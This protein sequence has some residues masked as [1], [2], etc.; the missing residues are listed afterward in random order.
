[1]VD[2]MNDYLRLFPTNQVIISDKPGWLIMVNDTLWLFP[3]KTGDER[4]GGG[5]LGGGD[6][7]ASATEQAAYRHHVDKEEKEDYKWHHVDIEE[8]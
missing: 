3:K 6:G 4:R 1:M 2:K 5:S 7:R 8:E